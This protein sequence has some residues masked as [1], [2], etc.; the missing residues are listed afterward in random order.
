MVGI[1]QEHL[2]G[3]GDS[4][5]RTRLKDPAEAFHS[6][7]W[8]FLGRNLSSLVRGK[9]AMTNPKNVASVEMLKSVLAE[10]KT[11][12]L[13]DYQGLGAEEINVLRTKIRAAG[14]RMLVAKNRLINVVLQDQ[15]VDGFQDILK[16]PTAL[17]VVGDDPVGPAKALVDFAD[18]HLLDLPLPKGGLLEGT[19]VASEAINRIAELPGREQLLSQ[20]IGL[21]QAPMQ[22]LVGV[23]EGPSRNLVSVLQNYS[24]KIKEN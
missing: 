24:E 5:G 22:Q 21:L 1:H 11:F 19:V 8:L 14:G 4:R 20:I 3:V 16:G 10:A 15:G 17:V 18:E 6:A 23:L 12:F 2:E 9:A 7:S 13:V